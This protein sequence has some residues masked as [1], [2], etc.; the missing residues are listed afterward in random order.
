MGE[1]GLGV[2][3]RRDEGLVIGWGRRVSYIFEKGWLLG[4]SRGDVFV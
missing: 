3:W 4:L 1:V 2:G